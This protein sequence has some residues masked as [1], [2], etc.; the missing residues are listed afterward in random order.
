MLVIKLLTAFQKNILNAAFVVRTSMGK[1]KLIWHR[2]YYTNIR[3]FTMNL[4][5]EKKGLDI[6][7]ADET[8]D[9]SS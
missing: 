1:S 7:E 9:K 3:T 2:I 5:L 6:S 4:Q 8:F